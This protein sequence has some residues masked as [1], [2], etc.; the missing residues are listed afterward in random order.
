MWGY[1][2]EPALF[3]FKS[4]P[5][6]VPHCLRLG[7]PY[8]LDWIT[9]LST[10]LIKILKWIGQSV[11]FSWP[12]NHGTNHSTPTNSLSTL[13]WIVNNVWWIWTGVGRSGHLEN[14]I[15]DQRRSENRS[16]IPENLQDCIICNPLR[17]G[18]I[19]LRW[20]YAPVAPT[21][22]W[23][24]TPA[25]SNTSPGTEHSSDTD[26]SFQSSALVSSTP[27]PSWHPW[28]SETRNHVYVYSQRFTAFAPEWRCTTQTLI[29]WAEELKNRPRI[30]SVKSYELWNM[31]RGKR[32][33]I[34]S[35]FIALFWFGSI[36]VDERRECQNHSSATCKTTRDILSIIDAFRQSWYIIR[37]L[38]LI[39][40][41]FQA[42]FFLLFLFLFKNM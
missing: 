20:T 30:L 27:G 15:S 18:F 9:N 21:L 19:I 41:L 22:D 40:N 17:A 24:L 23:S 38:T 29:T 10:P 16:I 11:T 2:A 42:T 34:C 33:H 25:L 26:S 4:P 28:A 35:F 5:S 39:P 12:Q 37:Q 32:E 13:K 1:A 8:C 31:L 3:P 6:R 7:E 36:I 14:N